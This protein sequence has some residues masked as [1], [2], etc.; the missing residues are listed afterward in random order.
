MSRRLR[1]KWLS[2]IRRV[3][4]GAILLLALS[5]ASV[6][7]GLHAEEMANFALGKSASQSSMDYGAP[8]GNGNDGHFNNITHTRKEPGAWWQVDLGSRHTIREIAVWNRTDCCLDRLNNAE[9]LVDGRAVG[10]IGIAGAFHAF[11]LNVVG[12]VV[13]IQL[14]GT[15]YLHI[16]EVE[17]LG[18]A[19][20][21]TR[22]N[23]SHG[24]P[25]TQ[26]STDYGSPAANAVNGRYDDQ[27]HTRRE[28]GA[29]W[30]VDLGA[31]YTI[32]EIV[33]F[34][35]TSCCVERLNNATIYVDGQ[36]VGRIGTAEAKHTIRLHRRGRTVRIQLNG[37]NYLHLK[38]VEVY[39]SR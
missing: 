35:R 20:E 14:K 7:R 15:D 38:E 30:Q 16:A 21:S 24:R 19:A 2:S 4:R 9:V 6:S 17:V 32:T 29:W 27:T 18:P 37:E 12:R 1:G 34:N 13:R 22:V 39:G 33:I 28:R 25:A 36:E 5:I 8:A 11:R 3:A 31:Q 26:S 10:T 23:L